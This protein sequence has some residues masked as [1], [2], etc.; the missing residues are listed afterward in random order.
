M[1]G[2]ITVQSRRE[3]PFKG[4]TGVIFTGVLKDTPNQLEFNC[5]K[6][7]IQQYFQ[8]N[9]ILDIEW[10]EKPN[11]YQGVITT[12]RNIIQLYIDNKPILAQQTK[13]FNNSRDNPEGRASTEAQTAVNAVVEMIKAGVLVAN[14]ELAGKARQWCHIKLDAALNR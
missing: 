9:S 3:V 8:I 13:S 6:P 2:F 7:D 14:D 5:W 4:K 12:R 11:T 10:E 1:R